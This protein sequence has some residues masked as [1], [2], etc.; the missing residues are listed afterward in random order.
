MVSLN[1]Q[2]YRTLEPKTRTNRQLLVVV[3]VNRF[4]ITHDR[5]GIIQACAIA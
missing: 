1:V 2:F 4:A 5:W 3:V